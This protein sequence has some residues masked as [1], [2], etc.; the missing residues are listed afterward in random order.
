MSW[1]CLQLIASASPT[2]FEL[3]VIDKYEALLNK[4]A[5]LSTHAYGDIWELTA[6]LK[7]SSAM[8]LKLDVTHSAKHV[9]LPSQASLPS[10]EAVA[11]VV[12][13]GSVDMILLHWSDENYE[14][15]GAVQCVGS[16]TAWLARSEVQTSF[17][18]VMKGS[19]L[20]N[21]LSSPKDVARKRLLKHMSSARQ[22]LSADMRS[23]DVAPQVGVPYC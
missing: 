23:T 6:L 10:L 3:A 12:E 13:K 21:A 7:K 14:H 18:V 8:A 15:Y 20:A 19:E 16:Q 17:A 2:P 22:N 11:D 4:D 1:R 5:V 9:L